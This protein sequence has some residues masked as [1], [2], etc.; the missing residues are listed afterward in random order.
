M[1]K[2]STSLARILQEILILKPVCTNTPPSWSLFAILTFPRGQQQILHEEVLERWSGS[3][4][5]SEEG[6]Y[7]VVRLFLQTQLQVGLS[8]SVTKVFCVEGYPHLLGGRSC[9]LVRFTFFFPSPLLVYVFSRSHLP[10]LVGALLAICVA[11][12]RMEAGM[13]QPGWSA[14]SDVYRGRRVH[15]VSK[16]VLEFPRSSSITVGSSSNLSF[17]GGFLLLNPLGECFLIA[18]LS[19]LS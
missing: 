14:P 7:S 6:M 2:I 8:A 17:G 18:F 9:G 13:A 1:G 5:K 16:K 19:S 11:L 4:P 15:I 3:D 10:G 12:S